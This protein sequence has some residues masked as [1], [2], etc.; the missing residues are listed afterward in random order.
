MRINIMSKDIVF[1][2][3]LI[4]AAVYI[5]GNIGTGSLTTWD[6]AVYAN[7]SREI[8]QT[9][10]WLVLRHEGTPWFG[11]PPLYMWCTAVFYNIFGINEFSVRLTS[12]IFAVATIMILYL[13][14]RRFGNTYI[15]LFSA[16]LLLAMPHYLRYAKMGMTDV[17]LTFFITLM[18][19]L[20]RLGEN[21]PVYFLL[22]GLMLLPA[23]M[24]KGFAAFLG[25]II[26]FT[27]CI[28]S[29]NL[30]LLFSKNF[31]VGV[32][33]S[34]L[35][36]FAWHF[37]QYSVMGPQALNEYLGV[38]ILKRAGTVLE[39][40]AGGA[41][42]YQKA[43][44]NKN[45]PWSVIV[46]ISLAYIFWLLLRYRDKRVILLACWISAAYILYTLVKTKLH[47]YIMPIYP[48]LAAS[49]AILLERFFKGRIFKFCLAVILMGLVVQVPLSWAFNLDL[50]PDIKYIAERA[51]MLHDKGAMIY[52]YEG[53]DDKEVFYL[54][55]FSAF[56]SEKNLPSGATL[57]AKNIYCV[58]NSAH[59]D[60]ARRKYSTMVFEPIE[61]KGDIII[62]RMKNPENMKDLR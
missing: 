32:G 55:P 18:I 4:F 13:F 31:I 20:F 57:S 11:K 14:A 30:R 35:L 15:A 41:N 58:I 54:G 28:F 39:G 43:I 1:W 6:E 50:N 2:L 44:F 59:L 36:M 46:Y 42:F 48:A 47:W 27:Y 33:A 16:L 49:S 23:Y 8:L 52:F 25:P 17:T 51:R 37:I 19:Y 45:V 62:T 3:L 9:G 40:H 38:Q 29:K 56:L 21:K 34:I 7:I 61:Q 5:L 12:G 22:S 26:L 24:T 53:Y 60:D 10:D